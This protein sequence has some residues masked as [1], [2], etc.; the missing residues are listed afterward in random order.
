MSKKSFK[1]FL[2]KMGR[3]V[4]IYIIQN[5]LFQKGDD[6]MSTHSYKVNAQL[7]EGMKVEAEARG[8]K[9]IID[10]PENVGG[11]DKGMTPVEMVL[12]GFAGCVSITA[13]AFA[14]SCGVELNDLEVETEGDIDDKAMRSAD[15][16]S[17]YKEVRLKIKIDSDSPE[18]NI[19]KLYETIEQFCPV[20]DSLQRQIELKSDYEIV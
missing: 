3:Y 8:H 12:A 13:K 17:G 2:L 10:E 14:E 19:E 15:V 11:T 9:V 18:E 16:D 4:K 20:S 5:N 7:K 1:Y 6:Y